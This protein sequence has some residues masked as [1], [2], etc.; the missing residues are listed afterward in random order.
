MRTKR[1]TVGIEVAGF[2]KMANQ[3][4]GNRQSSTV[5]PVVSRFQTSDNPKIVR[6]FMFSGAFGWLG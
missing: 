3:S 1:P 5:R 6:E 4:D 2:G